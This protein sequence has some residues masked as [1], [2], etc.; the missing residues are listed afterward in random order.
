MQPLF[1]VKLVFEVLPLGA[2]SPGV[3]WFLMPLVPGSTCHYWGVGRGCF[4]SSHH[5]HSQLCEPGHVMS[6]LCLK[7]F[8]D[9]YFKIIVRKI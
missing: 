4:F 7:H 8:Y 3:P 6:P 2:G 5:V 1:L 9:G